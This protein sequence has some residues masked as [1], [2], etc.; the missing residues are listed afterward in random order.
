M[1]YAS[2]ADLKAVI[3]A[4]DLELLSEFE[5]GDGVAADRRIAQALDDA[6]A[7]IDGYLRRQIKLPLAEPPH[8]LNVYCRDLALWRLY[9]NLGHDAERLRDLRAGAISW[10]KDVAA[11]KVALGD[12]DT[13]PVETSGGVVMTD[14]PA[15]LLTR[16]S[17]RGW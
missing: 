4:R 8:T 12:D 14:G 2:V 13:P 11:G 10:L 6:S 16:D 9:R 7:E 15:R 5:V 17:L 3:P 1:A